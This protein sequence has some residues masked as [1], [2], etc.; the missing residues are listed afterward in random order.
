MLIREERRENQRAKYQVLYKCLSVSEMNRL[1]EAA[2]IHRRIKNPQYESEN[3]EPAGEES[4]HPGRERA[5]HPCDEAD[6]CQ[7]LHE[8]E[9]LADDFRSRS[10]KSG[11]EKV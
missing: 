9:G 7:C 4:R 6:S 5:E 10:E 8:R 3:R 2:A 1:A 11:M